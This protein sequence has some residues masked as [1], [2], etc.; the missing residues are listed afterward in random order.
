MPKETLARLIGWFTA[1]GDS[2]QVKEKLGALGLRPSVLCGPDYAASL[3]RQYERFGTAI[4]A[5][6]IKG[7]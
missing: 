1:A 4:K 2:A 5:S 3:K 7:E 6:N